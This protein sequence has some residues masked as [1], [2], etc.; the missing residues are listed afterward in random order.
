MS[1]TISFEIT[2]PSDNE[3]YVLFQC[4]H[5]GEFF[6]CAP[7]DYES[8]EVLHIYCPNC[9]L[10]SSNYLTDDVIELAEVITNN[11]IQD[12]IYDQFKDMERHNSKNSVLKI[13]AGQRP[14]K[15]YESPI[16]SSINDLIITDYVCCER[17]AKVNPLLKM[18][19]SHCP[20]CGGV[21]FE[22]N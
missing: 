4:E 22:N 10:I 3:G 13:K 8:E 17:S 16:H 11:Y 9:G 5:C 1:D 21:R 7:S 19:A 2:I 6:K 18:S 14:K 20:F 15:Q 12:F